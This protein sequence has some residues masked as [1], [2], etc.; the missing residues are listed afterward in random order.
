[1]RVIPLLVLVVAAGSALASETKVKKPALELRANPKLA[2]SPAMIHFT[3]ELTGG[4]EAEAYYC[5]EV[6]WEWGEG[7]KSVHEADCSPFEEGKTKIDRRFTATHGYNLAGIY[8]VKVTLRKASRT[9]VTQTVRVTIR[10]GLGD[11]TMEQDNN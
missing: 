1:M 2:F 4:D 5:P 3:A 9:I 11:P 10:A 8:V 7:G 6:E